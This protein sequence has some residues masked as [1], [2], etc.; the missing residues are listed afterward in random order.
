MLRIIKYILFALIPLIALLLTGEIAV[1]IKFY[2]SSKNTDYLTQPF[3]SKKPSTVVEYEFKT[4][5]FRSNDPENVYFKLKPGKYQP[6]E[7]Y[8]YDY[9]TINSLGFRNAEFNPKD[10]NKKTRIFC[11]GESSTFGAESPD[12]QTWP[13]R[14]GYYLQKSSPGKYEVINAGFA[15]YYS[16]LY[17]N[18]I[19]YEL[20]NYKPDII[21]IY[22]GVNDLNRNLEERKMSAFLKKMHYALYYKWSMLY[23]YLS[24]KMG[25]IFQKY[26]NPLS[27]YINRAQERYTENTKKIIQICRQHKIKLIFVRQMVYAPLD[28]FLKDDPTLAEIQTALEKTPLDSHGKNYAVSRNIYS[29]NELMLILKRICREN[30]IDVIDVKPQFYAELMKK[31]AIFNDDIHL[32]PKG[33]DILGRLIA[34]NIPEN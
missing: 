19:R 24:E 4:A 20:I 30:K 25:M 28:I 14:L 12:S 13:A 27:F 15:A 33:N 18:L 9:F 34:D 17:L 6:P 22:A 23:T 7:P 29:H 21:I 26:P 3:F 1:R 32:T 10:K 5:Y 31:E 8:T 16:L 2:L 11:I